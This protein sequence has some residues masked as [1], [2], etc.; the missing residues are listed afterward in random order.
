MNKVSKAPLAKASREAKE[1]ARE[2]RYKH[3]FYI[4]E[5]VQELQINQQ[6]CKCI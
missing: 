1:A 3:I 4:Q 6:T 2:E 5:R